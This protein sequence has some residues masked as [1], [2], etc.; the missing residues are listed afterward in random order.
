YAPIIF[1][2]A[3]L[4]QD[5]S[6][7]LATSIVGIV[8]VLSTI[9]S[10]FLIDK[11]GRRTLLLFGTTIMII[12]LAALALVFST[13][14]TNTTS[15]TLTALIVYIMA[16]A[17]SLGPIVW[18]MISEIFPTRVRAIGSSLCTF[19]NWAANFLVSV[20]FLS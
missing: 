10:I 1:Q 20:T 6:A 8:N 7:I 12:S 13:Q 4:S 11:L 5:T 16:F 17:I 18:L 14:T 19:A 2:Q 9:L 15:L 3:G